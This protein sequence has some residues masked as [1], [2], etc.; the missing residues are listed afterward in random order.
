MDKQENQPLDRLKGLMREKRV[1]YD[2]AA[3][4]CA[5]SLGA[6]SNKLNGKSAFT[7]FEMFAFMSL[8]DLTADDIKWYFYG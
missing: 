1:T 5:C 8:L 2:M 4:Q 7:V 3:R 6:L